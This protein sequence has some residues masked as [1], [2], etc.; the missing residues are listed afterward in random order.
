MLSSEEVCELTGISPANLQSYVNNRFIIPAKRERHKKGQ[1]L[2]FSDRQVVGIT[3]ANVLRNSEQ[4][5]SR[6][7]VRMIVKFFEEMPDADF[8]NWMNR[9]GT[10]SIPSWAN[11][12]LP[13]LP[14]TKA[15]VEN[16][17]QRRAQVDPV[18]KVKENLA[19]REK[20]KV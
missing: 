12:D 15:V 14:G 9:K 17:F 11:L 20:V 8:A 19:R 18:L 10:V 1:P 2:R 5:C 16:V 3:I 13:E 6:A 7:Y 4:G